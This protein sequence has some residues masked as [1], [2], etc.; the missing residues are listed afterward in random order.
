M[1]N[2]NSTG[3]SG[4]ISITGLPYSGD[5]TVTA[6]GDVMFFNVADH[7]DDVVNVAVYVN[8]ATIQFYQSIQDG[9]WSLVQHN[10]G[11]GRYL[12]FSATYKT[13]G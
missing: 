1:N 13:T 11:S 4:A 8:N 10:A 3:A 5:V 6:S 12:Y 2:F 9:G 7:A